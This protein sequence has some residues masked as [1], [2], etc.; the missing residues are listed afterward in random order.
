MKT[1]KIWRL[2]F[3]MLAAF[4]LASCSSDE[5]R[6]A[7][8]EAHEK[9]VQLN[10][11]YGPLMVGTW[12]YENISETQRYFECLMFQADGTLTGMRKWQTRK[13]VT[14]DDKEQYT[15]WEDVELSGTFKGTWQLRYWSPEGNSGKMRNCLQLTATYDDAGR[16]Y[17]AYSCALTFAYADA[18]T[19]RIQGYYVKAPDGW[20]NYQRGPSE[21]SF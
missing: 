14:I 19:L 7:D 3:A 21:P 13:L 17:M 4:S 12:H 8:P 6:Y 1:M 9:T 11:Q 10:E 18:T 15:D 5:P 2:A 20:I 16:D